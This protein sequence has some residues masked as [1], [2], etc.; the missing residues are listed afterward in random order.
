MK[1]KPI[2]Y[3]KFC[4]INFY[5]PLFL[6]ALLFTIGM[7]IKVEGYNKL[8]V[9]TPVLTMITLTWGSRR[10]YKMYLTYITKQ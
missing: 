7:L 2:S 9:I 10:A 4:W 6:M 1:E 8:F 3:L 5:L